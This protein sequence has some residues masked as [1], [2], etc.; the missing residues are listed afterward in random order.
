MLWRNAATQGDARRHFDSAILELQAR[1]LVGSAELLGVPKQDLYRQAEALQGHG[2]DHQLCFAILAGELAGPTEALKLLGKLP[3]QEGADTETAEALV[4][5]YRAYEQNSRT[6]AAADNAEQIRKKLAWIGKLTVAD[7]KPPVLP[8]AAAVERV[9]QKL[10]W[11][12]DLATAPPDTPDTAARAAAIVP[13]RHTAIVF[14]TAGSVAVLATLGGFAVLVALTALAA[15]DKLRPRLTTGSPYG[16]IYA[17]TFAVWML[18]YLFLGFATSFVRT[19]DSMFWISG[20]CMLASL[21]ALG[22]PVCRGVPWRIVRHDLGLTPGRQVG[23]ELLA[24]AASYAVAIPFMTLGIILFFVQIAVA[25]RLGISIESPGHPLAPF[26]VHSGWWGRLQAVLIAGVVA[27]VVE[28][29]MFRGV[30]YRHL[31]ES[32][33]SR[34]RV[35]SVLFS[36]LAISFVFAVIHPQGMLAVP[37]LMGIAFAFC[38]SREFRGTLLPAMLAHSIHNTV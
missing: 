27:P 6:T 29:T 1:H 23:V 18:T 5:I 8:P 36:A 13:A 38:L 4:E 19:N 7:K 37:A 15:M 24:G 25:K 30:L 20:L 34:S 21:A 33:R 22:W 11:F 32:T 14:L 35:V 10:G 28:E 12:G 31:R 17:E 3:G 16:G 26:I 2:Y 9:R